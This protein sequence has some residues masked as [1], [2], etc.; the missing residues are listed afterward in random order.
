MRKIILVIVFTLLAY[1]QVMAQAKPFI[2]YDKVA[3]GTSVENVRKA[4][5]LEKDIVL[6]VDDKDTNIATLKQ[7]NVS[8]SISKRTFYFNR[9]NSGD[10]RLY[11]VVIEYKDGS[12]ATQSQ[13]KGLLEQR[14][15]TTTGIN[16]QSADLIVVR[17][18]DTINIFGK[19]APD[20]EVQLIQR[21]YSPSSVWFDPKIYV[22]YT[23]KKFQDEYQASKL[24][25]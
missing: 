9:W 3:W 5:N 24:G 16:F 18:N 23:W 22:Y 15:G 12:D 8:D 7:E 20:I 11:Q 2:G 14:Y 1:Y 17:S 10:Y 21:K 25:L 19:F 4:Y 6:Q 13:L